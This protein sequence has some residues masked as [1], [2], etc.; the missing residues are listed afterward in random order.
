MHAWSH[1]L[2]GRRW[3]GIASDFLIFAPVLCA[4]V[5]SIVGSAHARAAQLHTADGQAFER[6]TR[7]TEARMDRERN[8]EIP[9]LWMDQADYAQRL[10]LQNRILRGEVVV[11]RLETREAGDRIRF[12]EAL[13]HHWVGTIFVPGGRLDRVVAL[14]QTYER[15][16]E[17]YSPAV[18]RSRTLSREGGHFTIYLQL[19]EKR[20]VS[21]VLNTES[22]VA[23]VPVTPTRMQ[24]RSRSR[25]VAEVQYPD[26]PGE[27]E[28]PVGL[29]A[30]FLWRF[31]NYCALDER[32]KGTFVQ[33]ESVSLSRSVPVGL[34]WLVGRFANAVPRESLEFT[35][36]RLRDALTRSG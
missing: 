1:G 36:G 18:R 33:C 11:S 19:F 6:Y 7:V 31:N 28:R 3:T 26:T 21:V 23:Y 2:P 27:R 16:Q 32:E 25:R 22:N 12:A 9:F 34:N 29:D 5:A 14:M 17:I 30:G 24:V 4:A 20:I 35:L 8:G 15:Y 13:C 10:N